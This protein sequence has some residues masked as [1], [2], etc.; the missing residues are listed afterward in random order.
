MYTCAKV[1]SFVWLLLAVIRGSFAVDPIIGSCPS[2]YSEIGNSCY[3]YINSKRWFFGAAADC[4]KYS[5]GWLAA[6]NAEWKLGVVNYFNI[7]DD[8]WFGLMKRSYCTRSSCKDSDFIYDS[9]WGVP[10][11][12]GNYTLNMDRYVFAALRLI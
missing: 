4:R 11:L 5:N 9:L 2:E 8:T 6:L 12:V 10:A 3:K 1:P 7:Q